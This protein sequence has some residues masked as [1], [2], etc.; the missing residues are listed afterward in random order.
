MEAISFDALSRAVAQIRSRRML[1]RLGGGLLVGGSLARL[2]LAETTAKRK[3]RKR[4]KRRKK[5]CIPA[6]A[7][8]VCGSDGCGGRCGTDCASY[9]VC[10]NGRCSCTPACDEKD[11]GDNGCGGVCGFCAIDAT[12]SASG[13]CACDVGKDVCRGACHPTC[14]PSSVRPPGSCDCCAENDVF[15]SGSGASCTLCCSQRCT[16]AGPERYQCNGRPD[17]NDCTFDEQCASEN[18]Q[19]DLVGNGFCVGGAG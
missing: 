9:E 12:C 4:K 8:K 14:G 2:G 15:I 11:C 19:V 6:C 5:P 18:C 7:G 10:Q 13:V 3:K 16:D 1:V 17:G